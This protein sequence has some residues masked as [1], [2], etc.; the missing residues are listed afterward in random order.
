MILHSFV[1]SFVIHTP[2]IKTISP[3][4]VWDIFKSKIFSKYVFTT[5]TTSWSNTIIF[6]FFST[7]KAFRFRPV[8]CSG[9]W[10]FAIALSYSTQKWF[11]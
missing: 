6:L 9:Y 5:V 7:R 3:Q 2:M 11:T 1:M 10:T 8:F 4:L